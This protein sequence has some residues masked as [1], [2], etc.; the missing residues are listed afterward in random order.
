[1]KS[2][3]LDCLLKNTGDEFA[4]LSHQEAKETTGGF[5][6]WIL[7]ATFL[8]GVIVGYLEEDAKDKKATPTPAIV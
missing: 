8:V 2:S 5:L 7:L 4:E 3:N 6:G 1:M